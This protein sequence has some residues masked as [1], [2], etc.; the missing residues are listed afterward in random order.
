MV[1]PYVMGVGIDRLLYQEHEY[2]QRSQGAKYRATR[3]TEPGVKTRCCMTP[4]MD[5]AKRMSRIASPSAPREFRRLNSFAVEFRYD[6][7]S[8]V[9]IT[10]DKAE[11]LTSLVTQGSTARCAALARLLRQE[12][13]AGVKSPIFQS[14]ADFWIIEAITH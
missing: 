3:C 9:L 7:Q 10:R 8:I 13:L 12:V 11:H 14:L 2:A 6:D 4:F 1:P 5:E